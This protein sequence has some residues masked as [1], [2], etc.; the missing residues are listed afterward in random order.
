MSNNRIYFLKDQR[1]DYF[2]PNGSKTKNTYDQETF[3]IIRILTT[4]NTGQ[5]IVQDLN[6]TFDAVG[7]I[8]E[9]VDNAQQTQYFSNTVI[10]PT[11]KYRYDS[12][13]RLVQATG[14]E[15]GNL[16]APNSSGY[17]PDWIPTNGKSSQ[18][19][20]TYCEQY[21][22]DEVG[23]ILEL[24]HKDTCGGTE[25]WKRS[26][27]YNNNTTNNYLLSAYTGSTPPTS[28]QF[29]YDT[30]GNMLQMPH[31]Q[32]MNWDF[33]DQMKSSQKT[34]ETTYYV[35][36]GGERVRKIVVD[37]SGSTEKIKYE[38]IYLEEFEVYHKYNTTGELETERV[39]HHCN[40]EG[41]AMLL[42]EIMTVNDGNSIENPITIS[43]YQYGDQLDSAK[44][45]LNENAEVLSY[46]EYHPFGTTSF[47]MHTNDSEVSLKRY[48]YVHKERDSETGLYYYGARYY[49]AWL[50]RFTAC[51]PL[52]SKMPEW[53][54]YNYTLDNPLKYIDPTGMA[55]T[56]PSTD[57]K[58]NEDGTYTVVNAYDD[59]DKN[60][61]I[62]DSDGKRTGEIIATTMKST[63]FLNTDDTTGEFSGYVEVTF[64]LNNLTV[65]GTVSINNFTTM[66]IY[67]A[68]AQRLLSWGQEL[69]NNEVERQSPSTFY[70]SL[71]ILKQMSI[72]FD[73]NNTGEGRGALDF[74]SS[75]GLNKYTAIGAG[76]TSDGKPIITTLRAMGN[77]IF[78]ANMKNTKPYL[79]GTKTWYYSKIMEKVGAYNQSTNS[80]NGYNEGFPYYGEHTYSGSYIYYGYFGNFYK[81]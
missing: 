20:A 28:P 68:D 19:L 67:G 57:V 25:N 58:K 55:P 53:S 18:S 4:R 13:Y 24:A 39:T 8:T 32:A 36:S 44:L 16:S 30:H 37:T 31:L 71:E 14:R 51:D 42:Q 15:K 9:Q 60:V 12:L 49:A 47:E 54:P 10:D 74:K 17:Q 26:Y 50:C 78:G 56:P 73:P 61:Y 27:M 38:R 22:Y 69:F 70:G 2:I 34:G 7:N 48:K 40:D 65:S 23:N 35:Y 62:V 59:D 6:Y 76:K 41:L 64:D 77:I 33:A 52:E 66:S 45:E 29:S 80:G 79:L 75:L 63:D 3:R 21:S 46:E 72:N 5:D 81:K 1:T 11:N 43:R